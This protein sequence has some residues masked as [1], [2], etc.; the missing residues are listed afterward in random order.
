M[1]H[2]ALHVRPA[3]HWAL[4]VHTFAG[5]QPLGQSLPEQKIGGQP[6]SE[7]QVF[8]QSAIQRLIPAGSGGYPTLAVHCE[9]HN[10]LQ[11]FRRAVPESSH[12]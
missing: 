1:Q 10:E 9:P 3:A 8:V 2:P 4:V 7:A 6:A 11:A 12:R 5:A